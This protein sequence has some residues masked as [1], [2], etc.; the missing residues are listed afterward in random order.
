MEKDNYTELLEHERHIEERALASLGH[1]LA[2]NA[3]MYTAW[4]TLYAVEMSKVTTAA[5]EQAQIGR[6]FVLVGSA[7]VG[8]LWGLQWSSL[9]R[10]NWAMARR[11]VMNL[12]ELGS[13]TRSTRRTLPHLYEIL[14]TTEIDGREPTAPGEDRRKGSFRWS[15]NPSILAFTPLMMSGIYA[16]LFALWFQTRIVAPS[17][18][19]LL[20]WL[21]VL[22]GLAILVVLA[23]SARRAEKCLETRVTAAMQA[24]DV[25][26]CI[27]ELWAKFPRQGA[28]R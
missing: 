22:I 5:I 7:I 2:A 12:H 9:L 1:Y 16:L 14:S 11:L 18:W 24:A 28:E 20:G 19:L 17:G 25:M 27:E 6:D 15:S 8:Y 21:L 4:A 26:P 3:F 23:V 10:R 13:R